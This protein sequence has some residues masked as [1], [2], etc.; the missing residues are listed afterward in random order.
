MRQVG[1]SG[2]GEIQ[3]TVIST[4]SPMWDGVKPEV[5]KPD[6]EK[7]KQLLAE[8][9]YPDGV[10]LRFRTSSE[11]ALTSMIVEQLRQSNINAEL[12]VAEFPV[13]FAALGEGDFD[14]Y[15]SAQQ[16]AYYTEPVRCTDGLTYDYSDVMGGCGY[17]NEEYS[18]ICARCYKA[19]DIEERKA[20]YAEL[21]KHFRENYV[22]IGLF[23]S[24]DLALS[25]KGI[26]NIQLRGMGVIDFGY[27]Y[28][29]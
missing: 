20:A 3:D 18:E 16:F 9:G 21:Q 19:I 28:E 6:N 10:T 25:R 27:I 22:S 14:M 8:A 5:Y 24:T 1:A 4:L 13:H 29:N 17:K 15:L 23:S 11:N 2:F 7:A 26:N 12:V